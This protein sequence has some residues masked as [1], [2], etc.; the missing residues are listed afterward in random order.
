MLAMRRTPGPGLC[1]NGSVL[2]GHR[3]GIFQAAEE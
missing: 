3:D 1:Q 2:V